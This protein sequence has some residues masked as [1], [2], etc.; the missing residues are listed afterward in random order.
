MT[1]QIINDLIPATWQEDLYASAKE[2]FYIYKENTSYKESPTNFIQGMDIFV[3]ENTIDSIQFVHYINWTA[4]DMNHMYPFLKPLVHMLCDRLGKKITKV[5]RMKI[6]HQSPQ[7]NFTENNYNIVHTDDPN[8]KRLTAIYYINDSDGDT[9]IFNEKYNI[10]W[11]TNPT[12]KL[13]IAKRVTPKAGTVVVFPATQMHASSNPINTT[14]RW[15]LNILF[16][17]EE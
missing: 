12:E 17:V 5:I 15:V 4:G 10:N 1:I 2:C 13:T 7:P 14:S 16:E 6:N 3:D 8:P 11:Q 9:F